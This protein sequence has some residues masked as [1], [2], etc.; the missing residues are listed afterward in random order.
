MPMSAPVPVSGMG[1]PMRMCRVCRERL[2]KSQMKR[3][4]ARE[5]TM[6]EDLAKR[7]AGRGYYTCSPECLEKLSKDKRHGRD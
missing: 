4:V 1:A 5:G 3:W 7:L 6:V 2:P